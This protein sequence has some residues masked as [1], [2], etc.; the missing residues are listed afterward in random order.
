[1]VEHEAVSCEE[2]FLYPLALFLPNTRKWQALV[3]ITR[4]KVS[5]GTTSPNSKCFSA[6]PLVF[7]DEA[8]AKSCALRYG[9]KLVAE[10]FEGLPKSSYATPAND[11]RAINVSGKV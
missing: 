11:R 8:S 1:M 7:D 9:Q 3:I 10:Q 5:A 6:T 4:K 2:Y